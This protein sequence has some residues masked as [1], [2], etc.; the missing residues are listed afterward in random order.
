MVDRTIYETWNPET[1]RSTE[2]V[3]DGETGYPIIVRSQNYRPILESAKAL[4]SNFDRHVQPKGP[5]V[6]VARLDANTWAWLNVLGITK[7]EKAFK[8]FLNSREA[9]FYRTDDGRKL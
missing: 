5:F 1:Q 2:V 9:R 8:A 7:D 4:A 6:H 3:I